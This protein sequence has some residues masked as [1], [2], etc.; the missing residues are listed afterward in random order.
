M[1]E[2]T[3]II[4]PAKWIVA[5]RGTTNSLICLDTP[6]F[7][8]HSTFTGIVAADD[9]VP[10]AVKYPGI[11]FLSNCIGFFLVYVPAR[12]NWKHMYM[13]WSGITI[14]YTLPNIFSISHTCPAKVIFSLHS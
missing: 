12:V 7:S 14:K 2:I 11:W 6:F 4:L 10:T 3:E 9:W 1:N 13:M 5:Q 8:A